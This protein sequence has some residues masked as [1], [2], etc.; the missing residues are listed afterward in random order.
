MDPMKPMAPMRPMEPMK[1]MEP[2]RF[3]QW[4]PVELGQPSTSGGQNGIRYAFFPDKHRLLIERDGKLTTY[5]AGD[6]RIG[7]VSA[8]Q[9]NGGNPSLTF[10]SQHG[11]VRLEELR[12]E[13]LRMEERAPR[14][15]AAPE[16]PRSTSEPPRST[17]QQGGTMSAQ[18][19]RHPQEDRRPDRIA[20]RPALQVAPDTSSDGGQADPH[21]ADGA[22]R[23][24]AGERVVFSEEGG[25]ANSVKLVVKGD[26]DIDMIEAVEDYLRRQK[27]RLSR[28]HG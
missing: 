15:E 3:E 7:G 16:P 4:W 9:Q 6:H 27:R 10:S 22:P 1:P 8:Q 2:M 11:P 23:P 18:S 21:D 13:E 12:V 28:V 17:L 25:A 20:L 5:D 24:A 14:A 19:H 26:I